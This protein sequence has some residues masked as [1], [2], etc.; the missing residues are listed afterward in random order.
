MWLLTR[1]TDRKSSS[2]SE[3][4]RKAWGVIPR[5]MIKKIHRAREVG[6]RASKDAN[7]SPAPR[8]PIHFRM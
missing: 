3:R 1:K 4:Q 5:Y 6:E 8:A 7:L 2:Q